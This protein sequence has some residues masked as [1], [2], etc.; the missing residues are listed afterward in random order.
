M[1]STFRAFFVLFWCFTALYPA[2]LAGQ[3][4]PAPVRVETLT[5]DDALSRVFASHPELKASELEVQAAT[6]RV[7]QAGLRPNPE[8]SADIQNLPA[9]KVHDTFRSTE[10][11]ISIAQRLETAGK[12]ALRVQNARIEKT[13]AALSLDRTR[14]DLATSTRQAFA[15][16]LANQERMA[17]CRELSNLARQSHSMVL[18]RI[19][20]GKASPVEA[21]RS[22]VALAAAQIEEAKQIEELNASKDRL[23]YAWG[24]TSN[25]FE[26]AA[27]SFEI[28]SLPPDLDACVERG[29][30]LLLAGANIESYRAALELERAMRIPDVTLTGGFKRS[31]L[32]E[33]NAWVAGMSIPLPLFN[34]RRESIAEARIRLDKASLDQKNV[35]RLLRTRLAQERHNYAM[36]ALEA[37]TLAKTALPASAEALDAT[38]E[39]YRLGKFTYMDILDSQRT[40]AELHRKY[41]EAIAAGLRAAIEIE[42]IAGC[43][44]P[45]PLPKEASDG[46]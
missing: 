34:K 6:A 27:A 45:H 41:I 23:A 9:L 8:L 37:T 11:T 18:D 19:A 5:L 43:H 24:G 20:A 33:L 21:T 13:A 36:A 3:P 14:I 38:E 40:H 2:G 17:S 30:D 1:K 16:V 29:P 32:D 26:R 12:R 46:K 7:L 4:K 44:S 31:N 10:A 42:R 22:V 35:D 39:G 28:P 15:D 25:D